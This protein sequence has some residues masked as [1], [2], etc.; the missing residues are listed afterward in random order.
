MREGCY[1]F[2]IWLKSHS[3]N[4]QETGSVSTMAASYGGMGIATHCFFSASSFMIHIADSR[5]KTQAWTGI[6]MR[7][8]S[9]CLQTFPLDLT[10]VFTMCVM[11]QS[12]LRCFNQHLVPE[13]G[14]LLA[15]CC[16]GPPMLAA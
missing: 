2:R 4:S 11:S 1:K 3:H 15:H 13:R 8:E 10:N 7:N 6:V 9:K 14:P 12:D 5:P 16:G